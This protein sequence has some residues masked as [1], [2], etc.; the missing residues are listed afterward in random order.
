[1]M[2]KN[3]E[4]LIEKI[5]NAKNIAISGHKN[6][7]GD[8]LGSALALMKIIELNF[9]KTPMFIYDGNIPMD[10]DNF[11]LRNKACF[12]ANVLEK[13]KFDLYIL[14]DYGTRKHLAGVEKFVDNADYVVEFDHHYNDDIVG[15]LC[16]D[17]VEKAST[18]QIIFDVAKQAN[19]TID[20]DIIDLLTLALITDT[21]NF[22]FV[23]HSDVFIDAAQLVE[24]GADMSKLVNLLQNKSKKTVL[25]E[26]VTVT[27]A[28]FFMK[29][30]LAVGTINNKEYKKLDGRGELVLNLLAQIHGVEFV[31]LFKEHKENLIGVS[32][33]SKTVPINTLAESFGGGGHLFA[34]GAV[35]EGSLEEVRDKVIKVFEEM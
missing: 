7:D 30:R 35:L 21:G 10:L 13:T 31:V 27:N 6:L 28:E 18:S 11:P 23:R 22:K 14:V 3:I 2:N 9:N 4:I 24:R 26:T 25:V 12:C 1:M 5:K 29:G 15:D 32:L 20:S 34:A 33:R 8:A 19:W 16:F 17:D